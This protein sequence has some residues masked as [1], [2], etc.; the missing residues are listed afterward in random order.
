MLPQPLERVSVPQA[1]L[2]GAA[3]VVAEEHPE[4]W[5]GLV[6]LDPRAGWLDCAAAL[7]A[8]LRASDNE[9]QIAL[10]GSQRFVLRLTAA[11][12]AEHLPPSE[13]VWRA[14]A[15]YL[16][17]GGLGEVGLH[18][19]RTMA[20][21]GVRRL[22]LIGRTALPARDQWADLDPQHPMAGR[23]LAVRELES[24]GVAVHVAALDVSD[25]RQLRAFLDRYT[26]EA[27]PPIRGVVHAAGEL[28]NQLSGE[29]T[30]ATFDAVVRPKIEAAQV[31]DRLLPGLDLFVL[32]S[33]TGAFL[34]Q[35]G[36][37]NYAAA[38]AGLDAIA[39]DRRA[40]GLVAQSIGWGVWENTGL[41]KGYA[42]ERNVDGMARHGIGAFPPSEGAGLFAWL[43]G[44]STTSVAVVPI[45]WPQFG[46]TRSG[47]RG[48]LFSDMLTG[49][50]GDVSPSA[51]ATALLEANP[52]QRRP[53]LQNVVAHI[54]GRVL[55]VAPAQLDTRK[56][57]GAMGLNS[58][59][60]MELHNRLETVVGRPLSATLAWNYPT[61]DALVEFLAGFGPEPSRSETV[62][63]P[64][65]GQIDDAVSHVAALSDEEAALALR[66]RR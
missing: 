29:M 60:A 17:T 24:A 53:I 41:V 28:R 19:A 26:K 12:G 32:F 48:E 33:S 58:L 34:A 35:S 51:L 4:Y 10:R 11:R 9:D 1:A 45:D 62:P 21:H 5:G 56:A 59:M 7:V 13:F 3:R 42:G 49:A 47:R 57:L 14:D 16:I 22:V 40:R 54:V 55:K 63:A 66:S 38:N 37:A 2:W 64:V 6:D 30:P 23:V 50:S 61:V 8:Q 31:L 36:Q 52:A 27:W 39:H 20:A 43:C 18:I 15:A 65:H 25:E 44:R 46:R